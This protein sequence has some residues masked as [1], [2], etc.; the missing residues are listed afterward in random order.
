MR[1]HQDKY[2]KVWADVSSRENL[3]RASLANCSALI[4]AFGGVRLI[5]TGLGC[6]LIWPTI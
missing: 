1:S 3:R 6:W 2:S 5:D 4:D